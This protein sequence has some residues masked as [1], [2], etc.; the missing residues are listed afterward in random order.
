[1]ATAATVYRDYETDGIPSSGN[2]K[3]RK[4]DIRQLLLGYE[5]IINA[6]LSTGGL[7]FSSKSAL[8]ADLA[9]AANSMAWVIGDAT[10]ANNGIYR[11][12]GASGVGSWTRMADL[13]FSFIIASDVGAGTPNAIQAT[14]SI[15]VSSSALIWMNIFEANTASPVTVSFNGGSALTIKTNSGNDVTAGGLTA[16]MIVMG[17]VSGSTFRLVS[18]QASAAIVAAAEAAADRAEAAAALAGEGQHFPELF[19]SWNPSDAGPAIVEACNAAIAGGGLVRLTAGKTYNISQVVIP[20]GVVF[21]TKG[22]ELRVAGSLTGSNIDVTIG[23][24][25][26]FDELVVSS[27]G[28]E[29]NVD[30]I[31][32]GARVRI[33]FLGVTADVQRGSGGIITTGDNVQLGYVKTRRIDRPLDLYNTSIISQTT[34]SRIGFLECESYVRAFKA[35]FCSFS[36]GGIKATVRSPN[37][38]KSPGHNT[39]LIVGCANWSIGDI[40][41]E[42]AG[43]HVFRIGGSDGAYQVTKNWRVGKIYALRSGGCVLKVN[44]TLLVSAGVT[45]KAYDGYV[46]SVIGVDVGEGSPEGNEELIRLTHAFGLRIGPS[47]AFRSDFTTTAQSLVRVNDINDVTIES[48]GADGSA[49]GTIIID[50]TSDVDGVNQFGGDIVDFNVLA[51]TGRTAGNDSLGVDT[52]FNLNRVNIHCVN[53]YGFAVNFLRWT[54]GTLTGPFVVT[55]TVAGSIA[56]A[57]VTPPNN[58]NFVIRL[59]HNNTRAEGRAAGARFTATYELIA[60]MFASASQAPTGF[61]LNNARGTPG[62][63]NYGAAIEW[64]RLGSSRRGAAIVSKQGSADDK[65]VDIAFLVGDSATTSNEALLEAMILRY[66]GRPSFPVLPTLTTYADNAAATAGGLAVGECYRDANGIVRVRF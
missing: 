25:C 39:V 35:T 23:N 26:V 28:T 29:T 50:G 61:F 51:L 18:D 2:H 19:P 49:S 8:D 45:E 65:E 16:G 64:S 40:W 41:S 17:I 58:D 6:F 60:A 59:Q 36:L 9:H 47:M 22:A 30:I 12:I 52:A 37:A 54:A 3:V 7:I 42:D 13:P 66:T 62:V 21:G 38:S 32:I 57:I 55:G 11:K 5:N 56:P 24:D 31:R 48:V 27:P 43:E 20:N 15:P 14:T 46:A 44:P 33:G 34:G 1:M 63:G 10:V 53:H 4:S